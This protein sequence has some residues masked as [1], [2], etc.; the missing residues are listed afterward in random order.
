[1]K[2]TLQLRCDADV[3]ATAS[4]ILQTQLQMRT[5]KDY[6]IKWQ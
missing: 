6:L 5:A 2:I 4:A 3:E 1:M